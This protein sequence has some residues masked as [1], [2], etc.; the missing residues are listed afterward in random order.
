[1]STKVLIIEDNPVNRE[2][3]DYLLRAHGY[4]T[5]KALDGAI[6]MAMAR[7]ERP[8][9]I[10]CDIQMPV[11]DGIEV[12]HQ[13]KSEPALRHTPLVALTALAMVGDRDRILA[14]GF[15]GYIAKPLDPTTFIQTISAFLKP[16]SRP[17]VGARPAPVSPVQWTGPPARIL[18]V[19]DT[20]FNLEL[21]RDLL[22]PHGFE[23]VT[24]ATADEAMHQA[25]LQRFDL[26]ISDVGMRDGSGFDLIRRVKA[27]AA[28]RDIPFVFLSSTHWDDA[29]RD[30]GLRLGAV[31]YL[32]RP[33]EPAELLSELL[34]C[35]PRHEGDGGVA[36][37]P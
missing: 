29:A 3:I 14:E 26:I 30:T 9:L 18:V 16:P 8:D 22:E 20:P 25:H 10:L 24:V 13:L 21:K 28:L 33:M 19:D 32:L 17:A 36:S 31:R 37:P 11:M 5:V 4:D 1:V 2:L 27:E 35:L 7:R 15:D 12:A 34:A 23:V 6:G